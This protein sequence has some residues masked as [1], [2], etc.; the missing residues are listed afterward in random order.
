MP[1]R[2]RS[3]KKLTSYESQQVHEVAAWK[4]KPPNPIAESWNL[5]AL[6]AAKAVTWLLPKVLIQSVI[7]ASYKT[8]E[9]L[10][11]R[12]GVAQRA[13]VDDITE[14]RKRPL[15]EC[16]RLAKEVALASKA[17]AFAEGAA[18]GAGGLW[19]TAIDVPIL[20]VSA[21]R[22]IVR[23][24]YCYGYE[25]DRSADRYYNLGI[26]T[27]AMAGSLATRL[28]RLDQLQDL[29]EILV[30]ETQVDLL[31]SELLSFLFQ[32]EIFEEVPGIGIL[33]GALLNLKF[34]HD[35]DTAARR[36]FQE[37]WLTDNGKVPAISP[38]EEIARNLTPGWSG[39]AGRATYSAIYHA[40]FGM[41]LP[42]FAAR[43]LW[44]INGVAQ[45]MKAETG[46]VSRRRRGRCDVNEVA[47]E[48]AALD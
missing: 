32:L 3:T 34:M 39:L 17:V 12:D 25:A 29:N 4:S 11:N 48:R 1:T 41:A 10:A 35:V 23:M 8:A 30:E 20:F 13:G 31:R 37:R 14:L 36:V 26:L 9:F 15:E 21:L 28:E 6:Q 22:T 7:E 18:T 24:G 47:V 16:D 33:S 27:I 45:L 43:S 5:A 19:T 44:P 42:V 38:A 46:L 40:A 2:P